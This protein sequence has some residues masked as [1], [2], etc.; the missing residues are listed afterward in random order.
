MGKMELLELL[1]DQ[2][3]ELKGYASQRLCE[4]V[5]E[6]KI[7]LD[8]KKAQVVVGVRRSGKSV[9]CYNALL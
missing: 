3:A 1:R 5:E 4:R 7:K 2:R 9:L 6:D 8:S